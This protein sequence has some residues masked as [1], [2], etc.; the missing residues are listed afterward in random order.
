[1]PVAYSSASRA[2]A[3]LWLCYHY[4][5]SISFTENP[6][7]DDYSKKHHG[8]TP[9]LT[10]LTPEEMALENVDSPEELTAGLVM[11]DRRKEFSAKIKE[12]S[13]S[14]AQAKEREK[15]KEKERGIGSVANKSPG[16]RESAKLAAST[17]SVKDRA[18]PAPS[19]HSR[20]STI[21]N[22]TEGE[23]PMLFLRYKAVC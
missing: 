8:R 17:R 23:N 19:N 16:R 9:F 5:E 18:I 12:Q 20:I 13:E 22:G 21:H 10:P 1:M 15:E 7:A 11:A 14:K 4:V 3:F 2:R 6:Y